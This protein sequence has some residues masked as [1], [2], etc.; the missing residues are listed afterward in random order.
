MS[1]LFAALTTAGN[2]L[3]V[4]EQAMGV[5]QNNVANASTPGYVTQ[6]LSVSADSFDPSGQLW[7]GVTASGTQSA[8]DIYAE[9]AVWSANQQVGAATQESTS[10]QSLQSIFNISGT[11]GIPG[12]LT[13]L[14]SAFS[15]WATAPTDSTARQQVITAAQGLTQSFNAASSGVQQ[16]SSQTDQQLQSTVSQINQLAK[17]I[18]NLNGEIRNGGKSDAGANTQLYND[19]EQLSGL[20]PISVEMESD[21]TATVTI[22]GQTPL[23][24][25][26]SAEA[27]QLSYAQPAGA[28]IPGA[29]PHAVIQSSNGTDVTAL[30]TSGRLSGLLQFRNSVVPSVIGD[31]TEQGGLNQ[32]AQAVADTVNG[33]LTAGQDPAGAAGTALFAYNGSA[34]TAVAST[35]S[36]NATATAANLAAIEPGPPAVSNGVANQLA[37]LGKTALTALGGSTSTAF[38][39]SLASNIGSLA[40]SASTAQQSE[41]SAL[42]RAQ[43]LRSQLSGVSLNEQAANLMQFQETYQASAEAISRIGST[44][45]YLLTTMQQLQ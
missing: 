34:P 25:G 3:D 44:I 29:S 15:A 16:L 11:A 41:T 8:R 10:L 4:V 35:L 9:Q 19:L 2:A 33:L 1:T 42:T 23:V 45:Q 7:G 26:Q 38:Y 37:Q 43:N 14:I 13:N 21:G 36:L 30:V 20:A 5:V 31:G 39:S 24:M 17:Q 28:T 40:S 6:T 18:A 32:L 27:L 22:A 12:A